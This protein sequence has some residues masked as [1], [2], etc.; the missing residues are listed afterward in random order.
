MTSA[1]ADVHTD[2][3]IISSFKV[4]TGETYVCVETV[5]WS[6]D[7]FVNEVL[8]EITQ[9]FYRQGWKVLQSILITATA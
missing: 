1:A 2:W 5:R 4:H 7:R 8:T 9:S 3:V 6:E